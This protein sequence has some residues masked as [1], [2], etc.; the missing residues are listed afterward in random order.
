LQ[1]IRAYGACDLA[2]TVPELVY[3]RHFRDVPLEPA[4]K[5]HTPEVRPRRLPSGIS[6]HNQLIGLWN[7]WSR[8][9]VDK[10]QCKQ[11]ANLVIWV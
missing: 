3:L 8:Q 1:H 4:A 5:D 11:T 7:L 9:A 10:D 2:D 6:K